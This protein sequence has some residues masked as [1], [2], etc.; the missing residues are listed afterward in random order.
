MS[1]SVSEME[2]YLADRPMSNNDKIDILDA[3]RVY[4]DAYNTLS[5]CYRALRT[6]GLPKE[7][8]EYNNLKDAREES[9]RARDI[10]WDN[11]DAIRRRLFR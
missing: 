7:D 6:C 2:H 9:S 5:A 3:Y 8:P 10:A 1:V 4:L 11:Y